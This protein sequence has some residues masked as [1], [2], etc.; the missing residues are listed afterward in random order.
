[1]SM[2]CQRIKATNCLRN[3]GP[4]YSDYIRT[5]ESRYGRRTNGISQRMHIRDIDTVGWT[6]QQPEPVESS[7]PPPVY[8]STENFSRY[9]ED[10]VYALDLDTMYLTE[11]SAEDTS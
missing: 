9:Y 10:Y 11:R 8:R 5:G 1:M 7:I 4:E 2:K 3:Y 6:E